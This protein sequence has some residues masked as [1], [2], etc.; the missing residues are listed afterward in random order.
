MLLEKKLKPVFKRGTTNALSSTFHFHFP[1]VKTL[2][3]KF[4][5]SFGEK[6]D[7]QD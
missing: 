7:Q 1:R 4:K 3:A 5:K 2:P 6:G